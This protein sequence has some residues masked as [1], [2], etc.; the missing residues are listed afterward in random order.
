MKILRLGDM[1]VK[2]SNL[3]E[4]ERLLKFVLDTALERK[5]DRLEILGD[6][7]DTHSI[8]RLEV[9]EFWDRWLHM[10]AK[11]T[12]DTR[13]LVGN[14][15]ITGNFSSTYSALSTF[16][17][18]DIVV[19]EPEVT[20]PFGYLPY[21]HD[22][23][24][25]VKEA[26]NLAN[27]GARFLVSHNTY[28]GS[29]Y[30]NGMY[31]PDGV[32]PDLIDS[33][34]HTLLSGH[35]HTAQDFGRVIYPGTARWASQSDANRA[36]GISLFTHAKH[37]GT[38]LDR[39]FISTA[40]VCVP[41]ISIELREGGVLPEFPDNGRV[42][43]QLIGSSDWIARTKLELKGTC[44]ITTKITDSKKSKERK[45]GRSLHE[46]LTN[47]YQAEPE[48]KVKLLKYMEGLYLV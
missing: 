14:H 38:I 24:E 22:N 17:D 48:K 11:Q 28:Q 30:D 16:R 13:V 18:L 47:H 26:N 5:V 31:A 46:F 33:R 10:L 9:M 8:I 25:F 6:L 1:H 7:F 35:V 45:S 27:L 37:D 43:V 36:K 2:V 12:F 20:G 19:Y 15:D 32:D 39:E 23:S 40:G 42:S 3:E 34:I 29:K 4:S 44:S 21:I 41:L